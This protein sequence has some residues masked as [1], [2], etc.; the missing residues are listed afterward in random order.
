MTIR[1]YNS[2]LQK[3]CSCI[4][5]Q[6]FFVLSFLFLFGFSQTSIA[7][8]YIV[9]VGIQD[10]PGTENDVY[11]CAK[12]AKTI[13]WLFQTNGNAETTLLTNE[14]ATRTNIVQAM[15]QLFAKA[16]PT[17]AVILFY[18]GHGSPRS[19]FTY[20]GDLSYESLW[21]E[22][23]ASKASR[24]F[25]FINACFSG[26]MRQNFDHSYLKDKSVMF[27]LAARSNEQALEISTMKNGLFTAYL[28]QGLRG[29]ADVNRDRIITAKE[30]YDYVS[31]K[32]IERSEGKQ[33][34]VMWGKF[35]D[36]VPV[37]TW[38]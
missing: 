10:Y 27:F 29:S 22:F 8:N 28:Q 3:T 36:D 25:A 21:K 1:W 38:K 5:G 15:R 4:R 19:L 31:K 7:K 9:C 37:M 16:G 34:P 14:K 26:T 13:Q 24:R 32:V 35:S 17:D 11:L 18:C 23:D 2:N 20:D 6:V 33:H 12:D 30:L